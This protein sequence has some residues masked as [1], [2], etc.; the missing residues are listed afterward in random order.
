MSTPAKWL[1]VY[2]V[3]HMG[4]HGTERQRKRKR[5]GGERQREEMFCT[6]ITV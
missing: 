1:L 3:V 6:T 2:N 4:L 5:R